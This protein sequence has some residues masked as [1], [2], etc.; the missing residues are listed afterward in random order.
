MS[1]S[2]KVNNFAWHFVWNQLLQLFDIKKNFTR[3]CDIFFYLL[4]N[5]VTT[6]QTDHRY[7]E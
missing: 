1:Y 5:I 7:L 4:K 3:Y 6:K 2:E